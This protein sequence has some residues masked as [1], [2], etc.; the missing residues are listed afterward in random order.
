MARRL[1]EHAIKAWRGWAPDEVPIMERQ[2]V[3]PG[4]A[5]MEVVEFA[6]V[7]NVGVA[8]LYR[9]S[10]KH[11][12]FREALARA[13]EAS[14]AFDARNI[15]AQLLMPARETNVSANLPIWV[16]GSR[17]GASDQPSIKIRG[18]QYRRFWRARE[19]AQ[20]SGCEIR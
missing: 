14:E 3:Q 7:L 5:G 8:T 2:L 10:E 4:D 20:L 19:G 6:R 16:G 12:E 13:R 9:W 17:P 15:R 18:H 11:E 1:S